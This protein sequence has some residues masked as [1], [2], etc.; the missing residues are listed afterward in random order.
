[1][2]VETAPKVSEDGFWTYRH[3]CRERA[4]MD[5]TLGSCSIYKQCSLYLTGTLLI[6][7][8]LRLIT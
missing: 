3:G 7:D 6:A 8:Q 4:L 1:M 2:H 5:T